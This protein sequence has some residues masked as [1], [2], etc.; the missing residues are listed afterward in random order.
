MHNDIT[1]HL[2]LPLPHPDNELEDDILRLRDALSDID[3]ILSAK[4]DLSTLQADIAAIIGGAPGVLDTLKELADA[5]NNDPAF[6]VDIAASVAAVQAALDAL[7]AGD[8]STLK[9]SVLDL[10]SAVSENAAN[11]QANADAIAS[12]NVTLVKTTKLALAG[13]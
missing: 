4:A 3:T 6:A 7:K 11:I 2:S 13:L 9:A 12:A 1:Q 8:V 5:V 10:Q